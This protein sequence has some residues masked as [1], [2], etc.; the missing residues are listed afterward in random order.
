MSY[1]P[2]IVTLLH[3]LKK[4]VLDHQKRGE[5]DLDHPWVLQHIEAAFVR[6]ERSRTAESSAAS[7]AAEAHKRALF[8][9]AGWHR[10]AALMKANWTG[11]TTRSLALADAHAAAASKV[12]IL[13]ERKACSDIARAA[14]MSSSMETEWDAGHAAASALIDEQIRNRPTPV[15]ASAV[16][17]KAASEFATALRLEGKKEGLLAAVG[18]CER[19]AEASRDEAA[20]WAEGGRE[21]PTKATSRLISALFDDRGDVAAM[22]GDRLRKMAEECA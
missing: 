4:L 7:N 16:D 19:I 8:L 6:L 22:L 1:D 15:F 2:H 13:G 20:T 12:A 17:E 14:L 9:S 5:Q 10:L 18:L 21:A 11:C 3:L